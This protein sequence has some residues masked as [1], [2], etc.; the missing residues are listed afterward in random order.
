[1][2]T[3]KE[4]LERLSYDKETGVFVWINPKQMASRFLNKVAGCKDSRGYININFSG[5]KYK[6]HRLAWFYVH[7][8]WPNKI[9]H[10]DHVIDNNKIGNLRNVSHSMNMQNRMTANKNNKTGFLG[11]FF[12]E[13]KKK[14]TA[15]IGLN[16]KKKFLG[17]FP[18][19]EEAYKKYLFEKRKIHA[20]CTI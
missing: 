11:V 7:K 12:N 5:K 9:D 16:G 6:A 3:H 17:D 2:I 1:M 19:R 8:E 10:I 15:Q 20:A 14:Y 4:L 13:E 18:T